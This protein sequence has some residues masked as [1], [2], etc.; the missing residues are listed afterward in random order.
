[1]PRLR[2]CRMQNAECRRLCAPSSASSAFCIQHSEFSCFTHLTDALGKKLPSVRVGDRLAK[3][4]LRAVRGE[5]PGVLGELLPR[6]LDAVVH[7]AARRLQNLLCLG[8]R[9]RDQL[10]LLALAVGLRALV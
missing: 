8:F 10:A 1:M 5:L 6:V 3:Q 2:E 4:L 9:R 7:L